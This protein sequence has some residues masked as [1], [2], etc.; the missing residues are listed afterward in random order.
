MARPLSTD[1]RNAILAAS[2]RM[3]ARYGAGAPTAKIA[4]EAGVAEGTLFT[5]FPDKDTLLNEVFLE[6]KRDL[7]R[8]TAPPPSGP[9]VDRARH[10]WKTYVEWGVSS[11]EKRRALRQLAVSETVT[12]ANKLA[13]R[14]MFAAIDEVLEAHLSREGPRGLGIDFAGAIMITL[15]ETTIDSIERAPQR[16]RAITRV[17][18]Q[19]FWSA[20]TGSNPRRP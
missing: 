9:L 4:R 14:T 8:A 13:G 2:A 7:L 19:A 1:K 17:G 3:V 10:F 11:P 15:A 6:L 20:I 5:Y 18:F 16:R 12:L